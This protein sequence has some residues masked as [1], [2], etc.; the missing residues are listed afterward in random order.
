MN[1]KWITDLN[2]RSKAIKLL[3]E[4]VRDNLHDIG[5]GNDFLATTLKAQETKAKLDKGD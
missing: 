3:E 1:S 2:V 4:K 5:F